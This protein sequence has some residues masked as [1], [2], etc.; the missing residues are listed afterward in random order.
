M[1]KAGVLHLFTACVVCIWTRADGAGTVQEIVNQFSLANYQ[2]VLT[3]RL[4]THLGM[5]KGSGYGAEHNLCR[6]SIFTNFQSLGYSPYLDAFA[7]IGGPEGSINGWNVVAIKPGV[8]NPSNE[9]YVVSGHY[10][11]VG[12]PGADDDAS[13]VAAVLEVARIFRNYTFS[14]TIVFIAFDAEERIDTSGVTQPGSAH[15]VSVHSADNIKGMVSLDMV[16]HQVSGAS[17]NTANIEGWPAMAPIKN[18]LKAAVETYGGMNTF[19]PSQPGD[20]DHV[21]FMN[22]GF[23]ACVLIEAQWD[24]NPYFHKPSDSVDTPGD[25]NWVY[26]TKMCKSAIGFFAT[27][28]VIVD[29]APRAVSIAR[30]A[31]GLTTVTFAGTPGFKYVTEGCTNLGSSWRALGTNT[32]SGSGTFDFIDTQAGSKSR[33]FYRAR[34]L[35]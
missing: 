35:P 17:S 26:A 7:Y 5:N 11:S 1:K 31:S 9:I 25:I 4:F 29:D 16:A 21:A 27:K 23:Q 24:T 2:D 14:K 28:L 19:Q 15:Y 32:V 34:W 10:D 20:S 13:G 22:A 33:S 8:Q 18:D 6:E 12:N 30:S 3:N